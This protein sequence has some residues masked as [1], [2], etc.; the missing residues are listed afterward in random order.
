MSNTVRKCRKSSI[1][2]NPDVGFM[3][4]RKFHR[5]NPEVI[6]E[7]KEE[8]V[9]HPDFPCNNSDYTPNKKKV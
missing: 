1:G 8:G 7:L 4:R 3:S 6:M 9:Y 2:M 5:L